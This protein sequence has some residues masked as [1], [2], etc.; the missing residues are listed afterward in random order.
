MTKG[1]D[2][3]FNIGI[4]D[5]DTSQSER[6]W[7]R[8]NSRLVIYSLIFPLDQ[9]DS[10]KMSSFDIIS[11]QLIT[12]PDMLHISILPHHQQ[13]SR[14]LSNLRYIGL[15]YDQPYWFG[16]C[17][18]YFLMDCYCVVVYSILIRF[19]VIDE[20]HTYK[21]AF[22]SHTALILRRLERLCSYGLELC[23]TFPYKLVYL[24]FKGNCES[25]IW[26]YL[27]Y[28]DL[29]L[30]LFFLLQLLQILGSILW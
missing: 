19:V 13:F 30:L 26:F 9:A 4:Y 11:M 29:F 21:G 27:Q 18:E 2:N 25:T 23:K 17:M 8:D 3:D 15:V 1:F 22:G 16:I 12:N 24:N 20:T 5:G 6:M 7:L 14:I 28:M 10:N